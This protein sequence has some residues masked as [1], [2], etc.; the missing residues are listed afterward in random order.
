MR[1]TGEEDYTDGDLARGKNL[2]ERAEISATDR[3]SRAFQQACDGVY[4][5]SEAATFDGTHLQSGGRGNFGD[6]CSSAY[7]SIAMKGR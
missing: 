3:S 4:S 7:R 2:Y 5:E 1:P 6:H